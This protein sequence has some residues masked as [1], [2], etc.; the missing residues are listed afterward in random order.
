MSD[1]AFVQ[2]DKVYSYLCC[3]KYAVGKLDHIEMSMIIYHVFRI[4]KL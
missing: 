1:N 4:R 3:Q 2:I